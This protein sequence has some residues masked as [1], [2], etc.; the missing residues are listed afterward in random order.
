MQLLT[1]ESMFL[2]LAATNNT[3]TEFVFSQVFSV[4]FW[5]SV[6]ALI[7]SYYSYKEAKRLSDVTEKGLNQENERFLL[8]SKNGNASAI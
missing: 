4:A 7:V 3:V 8:N 2:P 1:L 6:L 5:L